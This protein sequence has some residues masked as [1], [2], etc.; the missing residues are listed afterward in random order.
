MHIVNE[1][2]QIIKILTSRNEIEEVII[3][4]N[5]NH[6]KYTYYTKIYQDRIYNKLKDN[7]TR[8]KI[9]SGSLE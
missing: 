1:N 8:N 3:N 2:N 6:L 7:K 4:H 5:R 9:L